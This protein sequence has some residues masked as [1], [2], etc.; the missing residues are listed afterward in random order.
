MP[1]FDITTG[2][3]LQEVDNALNQVRKELANRYDFKGVKWEID[4]QRKE[5]K[6]ILAAEDG[7]RLEAIWDLLREK[8]VKRGVSS[9]NLQ[10]GKQSDATLGTVRQEVTIAQG[11]EIEQA[12][13]I[14]KAVKET[15]IKKVQASIQGDVVRVSA[16]KRDDLQECMAILRKGDFEIDL[17]FGNFRE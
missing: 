7:T 3:D 6:L 13:V 15:G 4:F 11:I 10:A 16:P 2:A 12:R 8:F 14:V 1:S 5:G 9:K 17:K